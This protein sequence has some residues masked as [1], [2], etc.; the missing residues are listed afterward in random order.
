MALPAVLFAELQ[1][2]LFQRIAITPAMA[3]CELP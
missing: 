2:Q 3:G 1:Q